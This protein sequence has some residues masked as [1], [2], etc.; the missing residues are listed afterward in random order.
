MVFLTGENSFL[1]V[2]VLL[3][4]NQW[5]V[6]PALKPALC[7]PFL[8]VLEIWWELSWGGLFSFPTIEKHTCAH[9][10]HH[11]QRA[12]AM[13]AQYCVLMKWI[14]FSPC[15]H[16]SKCP[17]R[18]LHSFWKRAYLFSLQSCEMLWNWASAYRHHWLWCSR[19]W[20]YLS[21]G[22]LPSRICLLLT[23]DQAVDA[24]QRRWL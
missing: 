4:M 20:S 6:L 10:S 12:S 9:R 8:Q 22:P 19:V 17:T 13:Q 7:F 1:V 18:W 14:M 5:I 2:P 23:G 3:L 24:K 11:V 21:K 15:S 16:R